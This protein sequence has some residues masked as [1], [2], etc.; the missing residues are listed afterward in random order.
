MKK[1]AMMVPLQE[2]EQLARA[3]AWVHWGEE[4]KMWPQTLGEESLML[5]G[6][7]KNSEGATGEACE[8]FACSW[9]WMI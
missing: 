5:R 8:E 4:R 2:Q 1:Q 7:G 6:T 3:H 9:E